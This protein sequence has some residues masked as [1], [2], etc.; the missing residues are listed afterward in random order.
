MNDSLASL[1]DDPRYQAII[2][3]IQSQLAEQL[4]RVHEWKANGEL[5]SIPQSMD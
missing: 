5:A 3:D 1:H 4:A 2:A